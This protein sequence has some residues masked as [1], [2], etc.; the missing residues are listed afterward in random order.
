VGVRF[1]QRR[2]D[3]QQRGREDHG[4]ADVA[5]GAEDGVGP[6]PPQ[7]P[8][9]GGRRDDVPAERAEEPQARAPRQ[10]LHLERVEVE[11]G[12][13]R[14]PL[15]D[16]VRPTGERDGPAAALQRLG[17]RERG[18]DVAGGSAGGDQEPCCWTRRHG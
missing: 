14:E 3:P 18:Q 2:G 7:D 5:P 13:A 9:A 12:R 10:P 17:D 1:G 4:T 8:D 6:P 15:L 11:A 16:G